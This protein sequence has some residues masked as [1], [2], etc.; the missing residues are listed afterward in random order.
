[1]QALTNGGDSPIS[2][3][4]MVTISSAAYTGQTAAWNWASAYQG[5]GTLGGM[6]TSVRSAPRTS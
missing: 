6:L 2:T 4:Y 1:M 3:P 5:G